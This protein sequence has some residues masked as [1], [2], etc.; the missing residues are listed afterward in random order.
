MH[1]VQVRAFFKED[2]LGTLFVEAKRRSA[3]CTTSLQDAPPLVVFDVGASIG[4]FA[5]EVMQ[6]AGGHANVFCF[7]ENNTNYDILRRNTMLV[8]RV[9][10]PSTAYS[11]GGHVPGQ[12]H[13][14]C[15]RNVVRASL[16]IPHDVSIE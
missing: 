1:A 6:Q 10:R 7:E 4:M 14:N 13:D 12:V 3:F 9:Y 11:E 2:Q 15:K 16:Y 5:L 8:C